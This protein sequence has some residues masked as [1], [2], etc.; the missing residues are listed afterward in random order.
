MY[1]LKPP[2]PFPQSNFEEHP[3]P[4]AP[5][6][7]CPMFSTP[8][9]N[10]GF[11]VEGEGAGSLKS[12]WKQTGGGEESKIISMLTLKN[13]LIFQTGNRF[14]SNKLHGHS[15]KLFFTYQHVNIFIAITDIYICVKNIVIFY[16][17][18]TK[19]YFFL[20]LFTPK[21]FIQ[22]FISILQVKWTE[23]NMGEAG[24]KFEVLSVHTFWMTPKFFCCN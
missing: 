1:W 24:W 21:C 22:K 15:F 10:P 14:P 18:F 17:E 8:V 5:W 11:V 7:A 9:G 16:A 20:S 3:P 12:K 23:M 2:P 4:P 19:K 13:Y 6:G